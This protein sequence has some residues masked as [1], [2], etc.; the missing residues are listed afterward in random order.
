MSK[1]PSRYS[2]EL[3]DLIKLCLTKDHKRR[4]T[5]FQLLRHPVIRQK[6]DERNMDI[7]Q[8]EGG[9]NQLMKTIKLPKNMD[10]LINRL[11]KKKYSSVRGVRA[12]SA[13]IRKSK[14]NY[15]SEKPGNKK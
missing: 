6:L 1:I 8:K 7:V 11:P 14:M 3:Y 9:L 4:P 15:G 2:R 5:V 13:G 12:M 10:M